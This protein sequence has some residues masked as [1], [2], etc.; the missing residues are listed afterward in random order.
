MAQL[1]RKCFLGDFGTSLRPE[2]CSMKLTLAEST[3][4]ITALQTWQEQPL[5]GRGCSL[6]ILLPMG[7]MKDGYWWS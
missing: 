3:R 2:T 7:P 1:P 6:I 5:V 4:S